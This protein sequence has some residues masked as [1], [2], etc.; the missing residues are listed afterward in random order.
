MIDAMSDP[1]SQ[2]A[3]SLPLVF[4]EPRGRKKPPRHLADLDEAGRKALL[5][6]MES[7]RAS[8]PGSS[9]PTTSD[10]WSTTRPR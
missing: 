7:C 3:R 2:P 9:P 8:G 5:E 6:E 4:D 10:G 1:E